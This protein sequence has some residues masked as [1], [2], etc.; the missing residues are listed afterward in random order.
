MHRMKIFLI[1]PCFALLVHSCQKKPALWNGITLTQA[2]NQLTVEHLQG[3]S[4]F[5]VIDMS[6]YA[7][8]EWAQKAAHNFSGSMSFAETELIFPK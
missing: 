8:P 2:R 5:A 1:L 3:D 6:Y 4:I 7:K